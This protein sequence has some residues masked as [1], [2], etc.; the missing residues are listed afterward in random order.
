MACKVDFTAKSDFYV[1]LA[2]FENPSSFTVVSRIKITHLN[3]F[4]HLTLIRNFHP[5]FSYYYYSIP[6]KTLESY[7]LTIYNNECSYFVSRAKEKQ[8]LFKKICDFQQRF[9]IFFKE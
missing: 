8:Y 6:K 2:K 9:F 4:F 5:S 1:N 7:E 3:F